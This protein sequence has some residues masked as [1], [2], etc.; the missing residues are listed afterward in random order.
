MKKKL[1][2]KDID[3]IAKSLV[4]S[5][6]IDETL[7]D[8]IAD[9][10]KL[11]WNVKSQIEKERAS[12]K[13]ASFF[14][15]RW[16][17]AGFAGLALVF[18]FVLGSLLRETSSNAEINIA[19]VE[20]VFPNVLSEK[21]ESEI[22]PQQKFDGINDKAEKS[23]P[24]KLFR[25][26]D[27]KSAQKSKPNPKPVPFKPL[28]KALKHSTQTSTS[29]KT[30]ETETTETKTEFIALSY[31]QASDSGQ[32]VRVKVPRSMLVSLGVSNNVSKNSELVNAE[33]IIGDDGSTRAIRFISEK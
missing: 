25:Q 16:Q 17:L 9:S 24:A 32:V 7:I 28:R 5:F 21:N 1:T 13:T 8:E 26:S 18:A 6:A 14:G 33:V 3:Q 27:V 2:E 19:N 12:R 29:D 11:L 23:F 20:N 22:T 30:V 10:P 15:F 31:S 4:Q